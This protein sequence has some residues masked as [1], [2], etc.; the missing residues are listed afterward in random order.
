M[1]QR[2]ISGHGWCSWMI[3]FTGYSNYATL[4]RMIGLRVHNKSH[5]LSEFQTVDIGRGL[6]KNGEKITLLV[7]PGAFLMERKMIS[8]I[9]GLAEVAQQ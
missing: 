6:N 9:R 2:T 7:E 4:E 1:R 5:I 8:E 3:R